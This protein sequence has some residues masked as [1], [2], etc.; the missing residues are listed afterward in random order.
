M[1]DMIALKKDSIEIIKHF[2][3]GAED[4]LVYAYLDGQMGQA[5]VDQLENPTCA[6]IIVGNYVFYGGDYTSE[7]A[8]ALVG[9]IPKSYKD[10]YINAMP[11]D[12]GWGELI[13]EAYKGRYR[14][15][16]RYTTVK[17]MHAFDKEQLQHYIMQLPA[18]YTINPFDEALY[19]QAMAKEWSMCF[20]LNFASAEDFLERGMG[21]GVVNKGNLVCGASSYSVYDGGIEVQIT[22]KEEHRRKGLAIA[23]A[24]ALILACIQQ[25]KYPHWDAAHKGS[26]ELAEKL[27][28]RFKEAYHAYSIHLKEA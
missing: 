21:F 27:G 22:T 24:S 6:M 10:A 1:G 2:F 3:D 25:Q 14:R 12:T 16:E 15:Y 19:Q 7:A 18:D 28:Y 23:C 17:D 8:K 26:L 13:E 4:T 20:G 11:D 9:Y 5:W